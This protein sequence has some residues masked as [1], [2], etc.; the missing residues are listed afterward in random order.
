MLL[1]DVLLLPRHPMGLEWSKVDLHFSSLQLVDRM[2]SLINRTLI[3]WI[4][5][6]INL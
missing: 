5:K 6:N 3:C 1:Y 2:R 4:V